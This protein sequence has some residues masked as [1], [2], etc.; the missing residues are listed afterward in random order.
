[1]SENRK[2]VV[3]SAEESAHQEACML[4]VKH[5]ASRPKTYHIITYGCQMNSH[6]SEKLAGMM[7]QM[8]MHEAATKEEADFVIFNTCCIR[9]NAERKALGNVTWLNVLKKRKPKLMIGICGCMIQQPGMAEKILKQYPFVDMAFGTHNLHRFPELMLQ[10]LTDNKRIIE[11]I[12]TENLIAEDLPVKRLHPYHGYITIMYGC[13]NYCSYCIVPYVR[14]RER[15]RSPELILAEAKKLY[16]QGV[17]EITLLGQNVNSYG[18]DQPGTIDFPELLSKLDQIGI[19]RIRFMTSHPKDLSQK[20]IDV[21]AQGKHICHQFH[22]P[23]QAGN[24]EIL[25]AMNRRYTKE[26]YLEKVTALRKAIPDIGITTDF[27]IG[28][29]GETEEQFLD[30]LSLVNEVQFDAAFT[31]IYSPRIGTKAAQMKDQMIPPEVTK[32][33]I[34]RL[35]QAQEAVTAVVHREMIGKIDY[36]LVEGVS[37]RDATDVAG[38]GSRGI[39]I[40]FSGTEADKGKIVPVRITSS[41]TNTLRGERV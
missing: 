40:T 27:M 5:H 15:S 1:M 22:L 10:L 34:Q 9:D 37:K 3:V 38:K 24:N 32:D 26:Q 25:T 33:R 6:D 16:A 2:P 31:F 12:D 36:V 4:K 30:T 39:T 29:P 20:L 41:G 7:D 14:G 35:I 28:F 8:G 17:Q 19:P 18:N 23:I 11:V 21:I 13:N